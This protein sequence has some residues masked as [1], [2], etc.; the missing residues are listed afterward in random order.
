MGLVSGQVSMEKATIG[1]L[2]ASILRQGQQEGEIRSDYPALQL[3]EIL[4]G[5]YNNVILNWLHSDAS[6][7]LVQRL[8]EAADFFLHG[9][10]ARSAPRT[11]VS[12]S[13][14]SSRPQIRE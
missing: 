3:A 4:V 1:E 2:T 13:H 6:Y 5:A 8:K 12:R 14:R 10:A 11:P 7:S 9:S